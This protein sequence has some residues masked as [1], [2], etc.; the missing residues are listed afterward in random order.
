MADGL[1]F[2]YET[3]FHTKESSPCGNVPAAEA[4]RLYAEKG[5]QG[6]VI[7]DHYYPE[8]FRDA[9]EHGLDHSQAID[10]F[11]EGYR[12]ALAAGKRFGIQVL[13]GMEI[14]FLSQ[15][16]DF[17][18]YGFEEKNLYEMEGLSELSKAEFR[19]LA[20][21]EGILI[22]QAHPFRPGM[23][24]HG[25]DFIDGMEVFN[26]N[27]RHLSDNPRALAYA[28]AIG[29]FTLSGSDFHEYEDLGR[30]GIVLEQQPKDIK[31]FCRL[32]IGN[33]YDLL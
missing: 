11:L 2:R 26:G 4:V 28:K 18:I 33:R 7:T 29:A 1:M 25:K 14:R 23:T 6:I 20:T 31:E 9:K 30:G 22:V 13:L 15:P 10:L 3:H 17:L 19:R 24:P 5:Y 21:K 32:L 12:Q 27:A 16:D 8:R